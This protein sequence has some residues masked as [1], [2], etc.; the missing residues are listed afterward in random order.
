MSQISLCLLDL[1]L[2]E[3]KSHLSTK[4][5]SLISDYYI[6]HMHWEIIDYL[7]ILLVQTNTI[8]NRQTNALVLCYISLKHNVH[9]SC[10]SHI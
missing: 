5:Y 7:I 4:T 10:G 2:P 8:G 1:C 6:E 9:N 3:P